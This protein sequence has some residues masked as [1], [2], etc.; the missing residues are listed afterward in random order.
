MTPVVAS[1]VIWLVTG[2]VFALVFAGLGPIAAVASWVDARFGGRRRRRRESRRFADELAAARGELAATHRREVSA[3]EAATPR[4]ST[5]VDR[6]GSDPSRWAAG[7]HDRLPVAV[8]RGA[9][10]STTP[11]PALPEI[12]DDS[13]AA[14]LHALAADAMVLE[15][16][17]IAVDARLGIGVCGPTALARA[18]ARAIAVQ[19]AWCLSPADYWLAGETEREGLGQLPHPRRASV[20]PGAQFEF[21]RLDSTSPTVVIGIASAARELPGACRIVVELGAGEADIIHHLDV[22]LR[23]VLRPDFVSREQCMAWADRISRDAAAEGIVTSGGDLPNAAELAPLLRHAEDR[24]R[25]TLG[26]EPA[27]C[28]T[29]PFSIDLVLDG[30][31]A[32]IGGTTG[33]GKSELLIAWVVAMAAPRPPEEVTFLLVD[34]KG[35]AAF[36]E[37]ARLPHTVGIITDLDSSGAT[38]A[39][40]SLRAEVRFRE[41]LLVS[42]GARSIEETSTCARLVVVVDEFAAMLAEHPDLHAVFADLAARGRALGIHLVLCT[43][44]PAGVVRD[45]VLANAE[46]RISLRVNNRSDSS[47]VVGTA[48]AA[49]IA[50]E[51]RGRGIVATGGASEL[52]QFCL[53]SAEDIVRVAERW[54]GSPPPR[55]PWCEPLPTVVAPEDVPSTGDGL[56]FGLSDIP[57]EQRRDTAVYRP[58]SD[59]HLLVLGASRAGKTTTLAAIARTASDI[60]CVPREPDA[61]WD[62]ICD[63]AEATEGGSPRETLLVI[64]DLD[65]LVARFGADHR[66]GVVEA[67]GRILRDGPTHGIHVVASAQRVGAE[68]HVLASSIPARLM[69]R[70]SSRQEFVLAGGESADFVDGLAPGA[71]LWRGHRVQVARVEVVEGA[72]ATGREATLAPDR[73]LAI[74][75]SRAAGLMSRFPGAV[76]LADTLGDVRA[77]VLSSGVLIGDIE[78]WQSRWGTVAALRPMA[79]IVFDGCSAADFR[80]LTRSRQLPPPV[81]PGVGWR[82]NEDGSASRV[83][84][85]FP[86]TAER[87]E[88]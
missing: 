8:G 76:S 62:A 28:A 24:A 71:A 45:S 15:S 26:C 18:A 49:D 64:D 6:L 73:P 25:A 69:M 44:R 80:A 53:A 27:I 72:P 10:P 13:I 50:L 3:L 56:A 77:A 59:G 52:V 39:L 42:E 29:G 43:Q 35:G 48:A 75:S 36:T 33:S 66:A 41:R 32:V 21:G 54:A 67:L 57:E 40:E 82:L 79:Q 84:L 78:E 5:I 70:H 60:V 20:T 7:A 61:A 88:E 86:A 38:R 74:V 12:A 16:A 83:R 14:Q 23:G 58:G 85:R 46:L 68:L 34:F 9:L 81:G 63:L 1:V 22:S 87:R 17:P 31:H 55:R 11:V 37:L 4:A 2:S 47:A 65:S 19:V 51:A 30:P